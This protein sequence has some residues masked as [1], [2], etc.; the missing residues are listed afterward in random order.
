MV[1][2][3]PEVVDAEPV[4]QLDLLQGVGEQPLLV[5]GLPG[6][7]GDSEAFAHSR[8]WPTRRAARRLERGNPP[9]VSLTA[10]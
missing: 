7:Q 8:S 4:G 5:A 1:L 6:T 9:E 2:D 3:F 10:V